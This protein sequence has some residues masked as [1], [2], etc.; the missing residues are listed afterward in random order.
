MFHGA[1]SPG[2]RAGGQGES[3]MEG[4][5]RQRSGRQRWCICVGVMA[6]AMCGVAG[7]FSVVNAQELKGTGSPPKV[8]EAKFGVGRVQTGFQSGG[9]VLNPSGARRVI[10]AGRFR[11]EI[12]KVGEDNEVVDTGYFV[13][14]GSGDAIGVE[15]EASAPDQWRQLLGGVSPWQ[16]TEERFDAFRLSDWLVA[17][18]KEFGLPFFGRDSVG[19]RFRPD[20]VLEALLTD[21]GK[22]NGNWWWS[23]GRL[24]LELEGLGE[25]A[26]YEW[27]ALAARVGW[28]KGL[29]AP[30]LPGPAVRPLTTLPG[31]PTPP[32]RSLP[33]AAAAC[34]RDV[35][36]KLLGS[37][38][39]R[40]DVVAALAIEKETLSL[41]AERQALIVEIVKLDRAFSEAVGGGKG[42]GGEAPGRK[43]VK[44]VAQ[45]AAFASSGE[46]SGLVDDSALRVMGVER[47][48]SGGEE[49]RVVQTVVTEVARVPPKSK[50][51]Y[52]WFSLLG[53][54]GRLLAGVTD[55]RR[56]W[57]VTEGDKLPNAGVVRRI[58]GKPPGVEVAGLGLLPWTGKPARSRAAAA[59]LANNKRDA[60]VSAVVGGRSSQIEGR[61]RVID[62]DTLDVDGVRVRLWGIDAPEKRQ[63]CRAEGRPWNC[64]GLAVA[65]LR[66]RSAD[67]RCESKGKD[68]YGR[69]LGVC[70]ES[71]Q[72]VNGWLV[73]EGWALAYRRYGMDY[74]NQEDAARKEK[75]GVHR[76]QFVAPWDWRGGKRL[77]AVEDKG[78]DPGADAREVEGSKLPPLPESEGGR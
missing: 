44:S 41:C 11:P 16:P 12:W 73:S 28:T 21:G 52:S 40:G 70:F 7:E 4:I 19:F 46:G 45:L 56:S 32:P 17:E 57:F 48:E 15:W 36:A 50:V 61:G 62:G 13:S 30:A 1:S 77:T 33:G 35:L 54:K 67:V 39:E 24:H 64:G 60:P 74:V 8:H 22:V 23:R 78:G 3:K 9:I 49:K 25:V 71:E 58:T 31:G 63:V 53:K 6:G 14:S 69:V 27:R 34:P 5:G 42:K 51:S 37:A 18:N 55:G 47:E 26:T 20:G 65:A 72:D 38:T 76:G 66:S 59:S 75:K 10:V 43:A 68:R 2:C 29:D